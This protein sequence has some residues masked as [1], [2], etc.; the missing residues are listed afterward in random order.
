MKK[1]LL[2][3]AGLFLM[4]QFGTAQQNKQV[5]PEQLALFPRSTTYVVTDNNPMSGYN[6]AIKSSVEKY[7]K[8]TPYKFITPGEFDQLR[9]KKENSFLLLTKVNL[10]KDER[11]AE[12]WYLNLLMGDQVSSLNDLPEI[13][14]LP[15]D[16]TGVDESTYAYKLPVM[17]R[18]AQ[19]HVKDMLAA[20]PKILKFRNLKMYNVNCREMKNK[21]LLLQ[22]SDLAEEV[23]S[24]DK[25]KAVYP[26][27]VKIV[28]ADDIEN[29]VLGQTPN[30]LIL[31]QISP[32]EDDNIGRSYKIIY[33]VDDNKIY[34]YNYE[35][36]SA[37]HPSGMLIKDFKRIV[38]GW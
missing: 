2:N 31:H 29:A 17:I 13:L 23:N 26:Y 14:T 21:T 7:W 30:T 28:S 20:S 6:I 11:Q 37:K 19:Q 4:F 5:T 35:N 32:G 10:T 3:F 8:V 33:G 16:Y 1:I 24:L 9:T 22:Q 36:I 18:F 25:I 38:R 34:Y 12:Y 15:L 27:P